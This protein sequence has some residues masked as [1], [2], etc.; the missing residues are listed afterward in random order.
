M[1]T[2][3]IGVMFERGRPPEELVDFARDVER[4]GVDELWLVEDLGWGG[5]IAAAGTVLAVTERI[6]VCIGIVPAPLRNPALL[7]MELGTLERL[8][9]GRLIAGIGHGVAAWMDQVGALVSSQLTLLEET[10]V[11]VRSLLAGERV[12]STG[13]FVKI[14]GIQLVHPPAQVPPLYAGVMKPRSLRLSG[15]VADGTILVEGTT[16]ETVTATLETIAAAGD[17]QL[18]VL[19]FLC[20]DDD[21]EV[22]RSSTAAIIAEWAEVAGVPDEDIYLLGGTDDQIIPKISALWAAGADSIVL[23][24]VGRDPLGMV[25]RTMNALGR[26]VSG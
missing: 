18:V 20:A 15:R 3:R 4:L 10:I 12:Q 7:A 26:T 16:P 25:T 24:P 21:P 1:T 11:G 13:R 6:T 9:P 2:Q 19:A 22:V 14:D 8:H 23:R 5:A 17:H